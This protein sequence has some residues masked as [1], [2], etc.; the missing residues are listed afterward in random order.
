MSFALSTR[1]LTRRF[2]SGG[3]VEVLNLEVPTGSLYGFVGPNGAGKTTTIR[4]LLGLLRPQSGEIFI[5]GRPASRA[6]R[7]SLGALIESPSV[8]GHLSGYDNLEVTR[9]LLDK[10]RAAID[11]VLERVGLRRAARQLAR[12]YSL[13]MRQRLGLALTLL[14][15]PSVLILDEPANGL[16]PQGIADLRALLRR[17]IADDGLTVLVSS[18]LL[19]EV[20]QTATHIGVLYGGELK[21]QGSMDELQLRSRPSVI[22]TCDRPGEAVRLLGS[23]GIGGVVENARVR[24]D[25]AHPPHEINR[26]LVDAGFAVSSLATERPSLESLFFD[27]TQATNGASP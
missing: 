5:G 11:A 4:L 21:F 25:A 22:L 9:R 20:E 26:L 19:S 14:A 10:P 18:H 3:G 6:A 13:G 27:L 7:A 23:R 12:E 15:E 16:D 8:Y 1:A 24:I 2:S 17:F